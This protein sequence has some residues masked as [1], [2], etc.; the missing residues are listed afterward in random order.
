MNGVIGEIENAAQEAADRR[1]PPVI[2]RVQ[3]PEAGHDAIPCGEM[4]FEGSRNDDDSQATYG[5]TPAD[6]AKLITAAGE[7]DGRG[8]VRRGGCRERL[9]EGPARRPALRRAGRGALYRRREQHE[10]AVRLPAARPG[11]DR[12]L[13]R[14][15]VVAARAGPGDPLLRAQV[16]YKNI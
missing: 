1:H 10:G 3:F 15:H 11:L 14:A 5:A 2:N 7:G 13:R 4:L 9:S 12:A 8:A 6:E 16:K